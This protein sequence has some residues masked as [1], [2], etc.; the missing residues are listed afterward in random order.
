MLLCELTVNSVVKYVSKDGYAGTHNWR[1]WIKGFDA[2]VL[3]CASDHGGYARMEFG[4][5][6]FSPE[7][8]L[9]DWPPPVNC[10]ISIYY[11]ETTE[12]AKELV[13]AGTAHLEEFNR[14]SISYG[15]FAPSFDDQ[16]PT[17]AKNDTLN[18]VM[19]TILTAI[20]EITSVNTDYARASS[21]N[22][23]TTLS[24]ALAID[25]ASNLAKFYS[26]CFYVVGA[27][28]YLV[29]MLLDNGSRTLA[30]YEYFAYPTYQ[31][32]TPYRKAT[33][34]SV[35]RYSDYPYGEALTETQFHNT[36]SNIQSAL[37]DILDIENSPRVAFRIPMEAGKF[38]TIG[39]KITFSDTGNVVDL[40]S[41][42]RVRKI[43]YDF[44][45][46]KIEIEGEG[47]ISAA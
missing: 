13:Y 12:A 10:A 17:G 40:S 14:E 35:T 41:Y 38:P 32:K 2:P 7:L 30:E 8:F 42:I 6:T 22:V 44:M 33:A 24:A 29:D 16:S 4:S 20:P 37:D 1:R 26:H 21:P 3:A 36:T 46:E 39:E 23:T 18:A 25:Q 9:S 45:E 47:A 31:Y 27:T 43:I 28:A 15:L 11:T 19:T 5:I 34:G